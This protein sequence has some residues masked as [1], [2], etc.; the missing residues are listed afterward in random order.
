MHINHTEIAK[1][2]GRNPRW[3]EWSAFI[4]SLW[5]LLL[6]LQSSAFRNCGH[7]TQPLYMEIKGIKVW[8]CVM[9]EHKIVFSS[10]DLSVS[11]RPWPF[12]IRGEGVGV[13]KRRTG[14]CA[15]VRPPTSLSRSVLPP[16]A[17][18]FWLFLFSAIVIYKRKHKL[19]PPAKI[20]LYS[21]FTLSFK[22]FTAFLRFVMSPC[23]CK[24]H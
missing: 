12:L 19:F 2:A 4:S 21:F 9:V 24:S 8:V 5:L 3:C 7:F 20:P 14:G 17:I 15:A 1:A 10:V 18:I 16:F 22:F 11:F 6:Q 23:E 13:C